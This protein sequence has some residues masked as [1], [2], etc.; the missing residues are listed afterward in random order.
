[1][2]NLTDLLVMKTNH[3]P[4]L[5]SGS[6]LTCSQ[7]PNIADINYINFVQISLSSFWEVFTFN[8]AGNLATFEAQVTA[9]QIIRFILDHLCMSFLSLIYYRISGCKWRFGDKRCLRCCHC[10]YL[11]VFHVCWL[12]F[13]T[14][15]VVTCLVLL[16]A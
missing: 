3:S 8:V 7:K 12:L 2:Q 6:S 5:K 14:L 10:H 16:E 1:M 13:S 9:G 11:C 4:L 15:N